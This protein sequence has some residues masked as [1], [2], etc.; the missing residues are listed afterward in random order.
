MVSGDAYPHA[1]GVEGPVNRMNIFTRLP[2]GPTTVTQRSINR[3]IHSKQWQFPIQIYTTIF[4]AVYCISRRIQWKMWRAYRMEVNFP[5]APRRVN[6]Q[7]ERHSQP[8]WIPAARWCYSI[9]FYQRGL[10]LVVMSENLF[11]RNA[12]FLVC[13]ECTQ[14]MLLEIYYGWLRAA[15]TVAKRIRSFRFNGKRRK[16]SQRRVEKQTNNFSTLSHSAPITDVI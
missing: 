7:T 5:F 1:G 3:N 14:K 15:A 8:K 2:C 9:N 4:T 16:R 10:A 13:C 6:V 12:Y 11:Y